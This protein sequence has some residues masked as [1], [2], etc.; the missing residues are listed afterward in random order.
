V[1]DLQVLALKRE[2]HALFRELADLVERITCGGPAPDV[3]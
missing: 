3:R 1:L 2:T